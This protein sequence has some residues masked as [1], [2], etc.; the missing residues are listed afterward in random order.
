MALTVIA[1][2]LLIVSLG[3]V[4]ARHYP[5]GSPLALGLVAATPYL[6]LAAPV[7]TLLMLLARQWSG[8]AAGVLVIVLGASTQLWLYTGD[9]APADAVTVHVMTS[10]LRLGEADAQKVVDAV[11][12][13]DVDVLMLEELTDVEQQRLQAAGLDQLLPHHASQ[14]S[15]TGSMGT[16]LWSR[17]PMTDVDLADG[18]AFALV[19]AHVAVPGIAGPVQVVALHAAG[20]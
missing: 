18:F 1:A 2:L 6:L 17:Y 5:G 10:N 16:G 13:H 3:A 4:G 11:R 9:D 12:R 14:P 8:L 15:A 7:G 20:P 19:T